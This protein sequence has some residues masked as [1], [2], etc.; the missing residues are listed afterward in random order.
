MWFTP[1]QMYDSTKFPGEVFESRTMNVPAGF[2]F[3]TS[4]ASLLWIAPTNHVSKLGLDPGTIELR[5]EG[6]CFCPR[7]ETPVEEAGGGRREEDLLLF[8]G[9]AAAAAAAA[10][11]AFSAARF[12]FAKRRASSCFRLFSARSAASLA[13][14]AAASSVATRAA[15]S[16]AAA[17]ATS[18]AV[19]GLDTGE[20]SRGKEEEE[21]EEVG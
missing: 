4:D 17:A 10:A 20:W 5:A 18:S 8:E 2:P 15:S 14:R 16:A 7:V 13:S 11:A 1:L 3:S 12:S 21:E 19:A 6:R 9:V